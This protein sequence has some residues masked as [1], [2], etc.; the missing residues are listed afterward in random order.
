DLNCHTT[1][2]DEGAI[3]ILGSSRAACFTE[4]VPM[5]AVI[6]GFLLSLAIF[7]SSTDASACGGCFHPPTADSIV[8]GHRMV[9]AV[10][11]ARTV[12]WDQISYSG[13]PSEFGWV[14]PVNHGAYV[15]VSTDAWFEALDAMTTVHVT[16]PEVQ[17]LPARSRG[18]GCFSGTST[19]AD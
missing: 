4:E 14:L 8:T 2:K 13:E 17:C 1:E 10:S 12:L 3:M 19:S 6:G 11:P 15:Q 7:S 9:F 18:V 5:K 16:A